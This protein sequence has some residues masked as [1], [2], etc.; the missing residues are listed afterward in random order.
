[1]NDKNIPVYQGIADDT[2]NV[3]I[4]NALE[5]EDGEIRIATSCLQQQDEGTLTVCAPKVSSDSIKRIN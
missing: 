5:T 3:V 1:M 4:E 2:K